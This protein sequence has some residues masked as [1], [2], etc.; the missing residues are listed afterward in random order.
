[1][2]VVKPP[3]KACNFASALSSY[4]WKSYAD[5]LYDSLNNL[6]QEEGLYIIGKDFAKA[7]ALLGDILVKPFR[8]HYAVLFASQQPAATSSR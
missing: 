5:F 1:M 6:L 2:K 3:G 4:Y 8:A 7:T